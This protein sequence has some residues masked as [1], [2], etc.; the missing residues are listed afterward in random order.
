MLAK[1]DKLFAC[2]VGHYIDLPQ[3]VV[4]GDQSS[5]KSSVLE[6][7]TRLPFPRD[8]G[9]CTRFATQITF[10]RAT[11]KSISVSVIPGKDAPPD[12]VDA[13][14][15]WKRAD[16]DN[17][18]G[19]QFAQI[20]RE[21]QQLMGI[22][23]RSDDNGNKESMPTRAR[24]TFSSDVLSIQV[25]GP[26]E[27]H[28]TVIDVPGIFQR[29]TKDVTT[30]EDKEFVREMVAGYMRNPRSIMLTVVPANVDVATQVK[31]EI[32]KKLKKSRAELEALGSKR[33][34]PAEQSRFLI[35]MADKFQNI[36]GKALAARYSDECF[37]EHP[38]L[39]IATLVVQRDE[40]FSKDFA[41][42]GHTYRFKDF[43][44]DDEKEADAVSCFTQDDDDIDSTNHIENGC[45]G[46]DGQLKNIFTRHFED[47]G[48]LVD[49]LHPTKAIVQPK[50]R[51]ILDWITDL[52]EDS[53]GFELGQ[54]DPSLL[55]T[56][57][58]AQ[59][60]NWQGLAL[61]YTSDVVALT[62]TFIQ[63]LLEYI[64]PGPGTY[65]NLNSM[66]MDHLMDR[67]QK[68]LNEVEFILVVERFGTPATQNHYFN[69]NLQQ[70]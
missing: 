69:E 48:D 36:V 2:N 32:N 67:Y 24:K 5:G 41:T 46:A 14:R 33:D 55:A 31:V 61:G 12:H 17:L 45:N 62:H 20:M 66:I 60:K 18:G 11:V 58:K 53:R 47:A 38:E 42:H 16:V 49:I 6:G 39:K 35:D 59:T 28:L 29:V 63:T 50:A 43:W 64:C 21:A 56:L 37:A 15:G 7:L 68:A 8:S 27:E 9:L 30:K 54:F 26:D 40:V 23:P 1:I 13:L 25:S 44:D 70:W 57:L 52:Y 3:I 22:M 4:V 19:E 51:G 10:R 65:Q 34:T